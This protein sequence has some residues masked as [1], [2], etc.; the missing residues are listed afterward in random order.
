MKAFNESTK[1]KITKLYSLSFILSLQSIFHIRYTLVMLLKYTFD[2]YTT[3]W[4]QKNLYFLPFVNTYVLAIN[5]KNM[6]VLLPVFCV[7]DLIQ[8]L[9]IFFC[10]HSRL[11][12]TQGKRLTEVDNAEKTKWWTRMAVSNRS[13]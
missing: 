9:V 8:H 10:G 4:N 11:P 12:P 13:T 7:V 1:Y 3:K 2:F 5:C 6:C